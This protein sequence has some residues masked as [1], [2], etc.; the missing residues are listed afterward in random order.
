[1]VGACNAS[2]QT[3][4][5]KGQGGFEARKPETGLILKTG[6]LTSQPSKGEKIMS[7]TRDNIKKGIDKTADTLKHA[8]ERVADKIKDAARYAGHKMKKKGQTLK[9]PAE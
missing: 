6:P 2:G 3:S 1:M 5:P 4:A 7:S 8:T 9:D